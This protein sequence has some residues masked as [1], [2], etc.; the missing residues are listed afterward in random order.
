MHT[1]KTRRFWARYTIPM[2]MWALIAVCIVC[3]DNALYPLF[4]GFGLAYI[5]NPILLF[6]T[7]L[8]V[9][10]WLAVWIIYLGTM[11]LLVLVSVSVLPG[12]ALEFLHFIENAPRYLIRFYY[13]LMNFL[14]KNGWGSIVWKYNLLPMLQHMGKDYMDGLVGSF[15]SSVGVFASRITSTALSL[16]NISLFP[17]FF[18]YGLARLHVLPRKLSRIIPPQFQPAFSYFLSVSDRVM[19]GYIRGQ[20]LVCL[21]LGTLY[22]LGLWA[23]G[24]PYGM[25]IGYLA[26]FFNLVPYLGFAAGVV[27]GVFTVITSGGTIVTI[28]SV[29]AVF[30]VA[31][32][33]ES[34]ILTP[35]IV[36]HTVGLDPVLTLL[37]LIIGGNLFGF[38]GLIIAVPIAGIINRIYQDYLCGKLNIKPMDAEQ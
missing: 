4:L 27:M 36:G 15:T 32:M 28:L 16:A 22:S 18:Y 17:I 23:V 12:I 25:L 5:L 8:K 37:A 31:Q 9:P 13:Q 11:S 34:F 1:N 6:L 26:G 7:R 38:V 10:R 33:I 29:I 14:S 2:L 3:V 19:G 30:I 35:K 24:T 21:S 20:L